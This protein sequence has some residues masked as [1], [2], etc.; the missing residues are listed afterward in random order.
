MR[1]STFGLAVFASLMAAALVIDSI[2]LRQSA[3]LEAL[4]IGFDLSLYTSFLWSVATGVASASV[5][6]VSATRSSE[7]VPL[8]ILLLLAHTGTYV[9]NA[10]DPPP[11]GRQRVL[12]FAT[13]HGV[14]TLAALALTFA[15]KMV[16]TLLKFTRWKRLLA[17][18]ERQAERQAEL[19]AEADAREEDAPD[20]TPPPT[21]RSHSLRSG[22]VLLLYANVG[23][24]H[25]RAAEAIEAALLARGAPADRVVKLDAMGSS[26]APSVSRCRPCSKSSRRALRGSTC[27]ATCTT[28]P[29]A[30]APRRASSASSRTSA[31]LA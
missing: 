5:H 23:S 18:V 24:G 19:Q 10:I 30:A 11:P 26:P 22:P 17:L 20:A 1:S 16:R 2:T 3:Y 29:T 8:M 15:H 31:C 6:A 12:A 4:G 21:R 7:G 28:S 13:R 25:K 9:Y 27:S 14:A